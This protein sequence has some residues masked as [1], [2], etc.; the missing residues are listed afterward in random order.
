MIMQETSIERS[1]Y[2]SCSVDVSA[3]KNTLLKLQI[4][5]KTATKSAVHVIS[6]ELHPQFHFIGFFLNTRS[7]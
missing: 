6:T 4:L 1:F 2:N 5:S 7:T 3:I